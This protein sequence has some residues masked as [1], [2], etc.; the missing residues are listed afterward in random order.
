MASIESFGTLDGKA[1]QCV[2][3]G[4]DGFAASILTYGAT[5]QRLT[6]PDRRGAYDDIVLGY[7]SLE[8]Y[9][10]CSNNIGCIVGR[11]ANRIGG[12]RFALDGKSYELSK[13][14]GANTL[15]GGA[16]GFS[17]ANWQIEDASENAVTLVHESADGDQG[18][19]GR[20]QTKVTY[21]LNPELRELAISLSATTDAPTV[22]SLTTH[23][24]FNL[25]GANANDGILDHDLMIEAD[26]FTPVGETLIP[27][28]AFAPCDGCFDFRDLRRV[29]GRIR[30]ARDEQL[31][32]GRGYDH[33]FVLRG[34][35]TPAPK[36]A[37]LLQHTKSGRSM[38]LLTTEP[39][40]QFYTGNFLDG[41]PVGKGGVSYR[42]SQALCLEPQAFP[43]A[44]NQPNFPSARLAP[45]E[46]YRHDIVLR[47]GRLP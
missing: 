41:R 7:D 6:A 17:K 10:S 42:Q 3:L 16:K 9:L 19:P 28:G 44:P 24:Y 2:P 36:R 39:G 43:D 46:T 5:L 15:H 18:F 45:G 1:V 32:L 22:V 21:A 35:R 37:A 31:R 26:S 38:E 34:G 40:L 20:M 14:D 13:N 47:F 29:G 27:T 25:G 8:G 23:A 30:D 12:G 33:N 4:S 11:F